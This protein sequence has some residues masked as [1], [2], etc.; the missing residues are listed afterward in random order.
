M[1]LLLGNL[2]FFERAKY[3]RIY[4]NMYVQLKQEWNRHHQIHHGGWERQH[5]PEAFLHLPFPSLSERETWCST[6]CSSCSPCF[7]KQKVL[8][9]W[10]VFNSCKWNHTTDT[11]LKFASFIQCYVFGDYLCITVVHLFLLNEHTRD[12]FIHSTTDGCLACFQSLAGVHSAAPCRCILVSWYTHVRVYLGSVCRSGLLSCRVCDFT[13]Q[14]K[15]IF[16]SG[17][18]LMLPPAVD[19]SSY[20]FTILLPIL[21]FPNF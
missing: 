14:Y 10:L 20:C 13:G 19:G 4:E 6:L 5:I 11:L 3:Q 2:K 7:P 17:F 16:Q 15:D 1:S 12:L 21:T 9:L 8:Y 18:Q